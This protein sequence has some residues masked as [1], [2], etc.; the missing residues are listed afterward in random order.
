MEIRIPIVRIDKYT[1]VP[2]P[3]MVQV[4]NR[5]NDREWESWPIR[6]P[7]VYVDFNE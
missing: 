7:Q 6:T 4:F 5:I 3:C 1:S 2:I